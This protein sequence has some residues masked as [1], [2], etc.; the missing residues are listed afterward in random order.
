MILA[1]TCKHAEQ[2]KL[3]GEAKRVHNACKGAPSG[4]Q[5]YRCT[6]C[7]DTKDRKPE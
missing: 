3:H 2:D 7:K 5:R 4:M 6:V 1:C